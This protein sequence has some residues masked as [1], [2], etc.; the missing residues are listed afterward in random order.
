VYRPTLYNKLKKYKLTDR[1]EE[2]R[3]QATKVVSE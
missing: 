3:P 2:R 1:I